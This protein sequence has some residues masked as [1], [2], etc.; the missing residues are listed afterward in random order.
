MAAEKTG[1]L[2]V[3]VFLEKEA[4]AAGNA[5]ERISNKAFFTFLLA[6]Y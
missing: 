6:D 4:V 3:T 1:E 2:D 5:H